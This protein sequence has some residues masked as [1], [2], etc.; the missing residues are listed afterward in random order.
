MAS[1]TAEHRT[2]GW[3]LDVV[4]GIV[5]AAAG[6]VIAVNV[7]ILSGMGA[8]YESSLAEVFR[9]NV[10]VGLVVVAVLITGPVAGVIVGRRLRRPR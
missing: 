4:G 9:E 1:A 3:V 2:R 8:G 10:V 7:V 6:A 5:G